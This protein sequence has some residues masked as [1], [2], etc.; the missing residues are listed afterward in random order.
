MEALTGWPQDGTPR[1]RM[2][3]MVVDEGSRGRGRV[4]EAK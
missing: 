2:M 4:I 3:M 1:Q